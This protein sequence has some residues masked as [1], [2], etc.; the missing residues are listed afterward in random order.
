MEY[1]Y[2][3]VISL[4]VISL[5][6]AGCVGRKPTKTYIF[7]KNNSITQ[8][9]ASVVTNESK[10]TY[11]FGWEIEFKTSNQATRELVG[12]PINTSVEKQILNIS[13]HRKC[14]IAQTLAYNYTTENIKG[15]ISNAGKPPR[16]LSKDV[17][18][19]KGGIPKKIWTKY[20][21]SNVKVELKGQKG[22]NITCQ[23]Q[24]N[25]IDIN[26]ETS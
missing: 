2:I 5:L 10:K 23:V 26:R 15:N 17:L 1:R 6:L 11:N 12:T 14:K 8:Q 20:R 4:L 24:E 18:D 22:A 7:K 25:S 19:A 3:A 9:K 13:A 16:P 21:A